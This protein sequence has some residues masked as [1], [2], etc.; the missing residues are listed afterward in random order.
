MT[1]IPTIALGNF[2]HKDAELAKGR[3]A[4]VDLYFYE[5]E[6]ELGNLR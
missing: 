5:F 1:L 2:H 3:G 6:R 4:V